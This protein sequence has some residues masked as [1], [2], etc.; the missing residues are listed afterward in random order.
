MG[1]SKNMLRDTVLAAQ[2]R[3]TRTRRRA[4]TTHL[5]TPIG[6]AV[7]MHSSL[8]ES[9]ARASPVLLVQQPA[10]CK[11]LQENPSVFPFNQNFHIHSHVWCGFFLVCMQL[12]CKQKIPFV[13]KIANKKVFSVHNIA[14]GYGDLYSFPSIMGAHQN[15]VQ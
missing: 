11:L 14:D 2:R 1:S 7:G 3:L 13:C 9:E 5:F 4:I 8:I 12:F 10:I 6:E 15:N